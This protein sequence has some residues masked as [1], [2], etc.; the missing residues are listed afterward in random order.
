[1]QIFALIGPSGTGKSH[2]AIMVAHQTQSDVIIDDGLLIKGNQI[3]IGTTAKKQSTRIG[4][5]KT[6]LFNDPTMAKLAADTIIKYNPERI[7]ILGTS[8]GMVQRIANTLNLPEISKYIKI[9]EVASPAEIN[10]ARLNRTKYSRHVI[11]A[12]TI[13]VLRGFPGILIEPLRILI[14][15]EK[16]KKR[17][18]KSWHEQSVVRPTFTCYGNMTISE[19]AISSIIEISTREIS[20]IKN[21]GK[22]V[23]NQ[24]E[25]GL[26]VEI[27]PAFYF[28]NS[29]S[30]VSAKLQT[31]IKDN[32]EYM[33]GLSVKSINI[34]IKNVQMK[35]TGFR[36]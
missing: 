12:P 1:M 16:G 29:L 28:G 9:E 8:V 26:I 21:P 31:I 24:T 7:L 30:E 19:H 35:R 27:A 33:T 34:S 32:V 18:V 13:E 20:A 14:G 36:R 23:I 22:I 3:L 6:A 10:K 25:N 17:Q 11:P 2:R 4:A 15:K 5:I